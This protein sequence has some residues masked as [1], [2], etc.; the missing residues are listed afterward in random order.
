VSLD[1]FVTKE[2]ATFDAG[3]LGTWSQDKALCII[4]RDGDAGYRIT[5]ADGDYAREFEAMLLRIGEAQVLD[6]SVKDEDD[7][8]VSTHA[9]V[10]VWVEGTLLRWAYLD[11]EWLRSQATQQL[12]HRPGKRVLLTGPGAAVRALLMKH[13]ADER[14][15]GDVAAFQRMQ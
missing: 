10:R 9:A 15:H 4:R 7:F 12:P 3:L 1:P 6:L 8:R 13:G 5:Y 11:S 2:E 14:A